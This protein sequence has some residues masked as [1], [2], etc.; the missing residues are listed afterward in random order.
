VVYAV[1]S[2]VFTNPLMKIDTTDLKVE[3][4]GKLHVTMATLTSQNVTVEDGG[5]IRADGTGYS[6]YDHSNSA[7]GTMQ[8]RS[9]LF[10]SSGYAPES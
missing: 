1:T 3:G 5:A 7:L 2:P 9:A 4:G 10:C 6:I 8:N